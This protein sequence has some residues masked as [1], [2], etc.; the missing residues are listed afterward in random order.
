MDLPEFSPSDVI[1]RKRI[2]THR[3]TLVN[4]NIIQKPTRYTD[5]KNDVQNLDG[6]KK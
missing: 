2:F 4:T 3:E 1:V 5:T 6:Y